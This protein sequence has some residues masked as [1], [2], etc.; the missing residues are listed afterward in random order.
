[1]AARRSLRYTDGGLTAGFKNEPQPA[2]GRSDATIASE[3]N[4]DGPA[5]AS[6]G[7]IPEL[8]VRTCPNCSARLEERSCKL[9]CRC[10]Y[11]ASCSDFQ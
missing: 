11:Y 7:D 9:I 10:G 5:R 2:D 3:D 8:L 6:S 1:M 4:R